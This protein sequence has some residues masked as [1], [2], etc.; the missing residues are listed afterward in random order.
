MNHHPSLRIAAGFN[1][2]FSQASSIVQ[3][4]AS[5]AKKY[6]MMMGSGEISSPSGALMAAPKPEKPRKPYAKL[7]AGERVAIVADYSKGG[8]SV[9]DL[10]RRYNRERGVIVYTLKAAGITPKPSH[11]RKPEILGLIQQG[12][13]TREISKRLNV[14]ESYVGDIRRVHTTTKEAK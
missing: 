10:A 3:F 4:C 6:K 5:H 9:S 7:T 1:D 13:D 11:S 14:C 8:A 2:S 12:L